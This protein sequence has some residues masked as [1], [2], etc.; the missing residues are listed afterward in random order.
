MLE[1]NTES[2]LVRSRNEMEGPRGTAIWRRRGK[3]QVQLRCGNEK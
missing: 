2:K 1:I 3:H